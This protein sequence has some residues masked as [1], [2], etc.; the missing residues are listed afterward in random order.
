[1][2]EKYQKYQFE[3]FVK[4]DSFRAW[5]IEN[6]VEDIIFWEKYQ[7]ENISQQKSILLAKAF[8]ENLKGEE[9]NVSEHELDEITQHIINQGKE[10]KLSIW[11]NPIFRIAASVALLL[12]VGFF[13]YKFIAEKN[14]SSGIASTQNKTS[15]KFVETSNATDKVQVITLEDGSKVE[16][17]PQSKIK[18]SNPFES[19]KRVVYLNGK[20]FFDITKNPE[21]PFWVHTDKLSTQVLGTSFLVNAYE[22][23]K[24]A[25]VQVKTG[26]VSVYL[27]KD[28]KTLKENENSRLA[29]IVLTPNQQASFSEKEDRLVKSIVETP[30]LLISPQ[31]E[32]FV[33]E[34]KPLK[35]VFAVLSKAYGITFTYNEKIIEN[36]YLTAN[37]EVES[38]YEKLNLICRITHSTYEIV[39]A[40]VIIYSKG[41]N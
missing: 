37:L 27:Q 23:N 9:V 31:K 25:S 12:G 35:D 19:N 15:D 34:E 38:L 5:V 41:C 26:K 39:D 14:L 40:Q 30:E 8:L 20:A 11:R 28:L 16:L 18:Y 21:K 6:R 36:C 1:M 10:N 29:G 32:E 22:E 24:D 2:K 3:D 7:T 4:D 13:A 17:Y 33:F